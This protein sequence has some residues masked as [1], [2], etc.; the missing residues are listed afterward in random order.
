MFIHDDG[1]ATT[2]QIQNV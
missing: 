1:N 2:L